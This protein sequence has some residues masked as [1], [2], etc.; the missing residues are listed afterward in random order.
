MD[1]P[2]LSFLFSF[3]PSLLPAYSR[4][5]TLIS[6]GDGGG[7]GGLKLGKPLPLLP[8]VSLSVVIAGRVDDVAY[9]Y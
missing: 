1:L 7:G 9:K 5:I 3:P 8:R 4:K 6:F 2:F